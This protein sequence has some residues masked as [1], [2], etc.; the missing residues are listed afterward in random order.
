VTAVT[1]AG[2]LA[3]LFGSAF[4]PAVRAA[5]V[6]NVLPVTDVTA[7][8]G[9]A[10][11][12]STTATSPGYDGSSV[13]GANVT[14]YYAVASKVIQFQ[15]VYGTTAEAAA[16]IPASSGTVTY[17]LTAGTI[18]SITGT[19]AYTNVVIASDLKSVTMLSD[20]SAT[21]AELAAVKVNVTA[22]ASGTMKMT[23]AFTDSAAAAFSSNVT[24]NIVAA[25]TAGTVTSISDTVTT[26]CSECR[27]TIS[28]A[29]VI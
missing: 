12:G 4:V 6:A 15:Y 13:D 11:F 17:T 29:V 22:P 14:Q 27:K 5:D 2:L 28:D 8:A 26:F 19:A 1:T 7:A 24:L 10:G 21:A 3:G 23:I 25:A 9:K 20:A 18:K 16:E